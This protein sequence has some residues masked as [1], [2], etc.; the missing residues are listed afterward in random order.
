MLSA[1][2]HPFHLVPQPDR[3]LLQRVRLRELLYAGYHEAGD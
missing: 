2:P 3:V 1:A